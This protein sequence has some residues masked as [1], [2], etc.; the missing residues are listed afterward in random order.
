MG[1][2]P[3]TP[4]GCSL[5]CQCASEEM[6]QKEFNQD[7]MVI[8]EIRGKRESREVNAILLTREESEDFERRQQHE[9]YTHSVCS[10]SICQTPTMLKRYSMRFKL[11]KAVNIYPRN[12]PSAKAIHGRLSSQQCCI[13]CRAFWIYSKVLD[14][15]VKWQTG[16]SQGTNLLHS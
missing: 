7:E 12:S 13:S 9:S 11:S 4:G 1:G 16:A 3:S 10:N 8:D 5:S 15:K 2:S 6:N 14:S